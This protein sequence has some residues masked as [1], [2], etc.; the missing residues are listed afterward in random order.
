VEFLTN[1]NTYASPKS[2]LK[3]IRGKAE[4]RRQRAEENKVIFNTTD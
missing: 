4:G 2:N 3:L 1:F